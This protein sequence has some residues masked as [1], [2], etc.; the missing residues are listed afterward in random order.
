MKSFWV[1]CP[2][3]KAPCP[4]ASSCMSFGS[5]SRQCQQALSPTY[6]TDSEESRNSHDSIHIQT[7]LM[8]LLL[9]NAKNSQEGVFFLLWRLQNPHQQA[10]VAPFTQLLKTPLC[11]KPLTLIWHQAGSWQ[12]TASSSFHPPP[13]LPFAFCPLVASCLIPVQAL[14]RE[15]KVVFATCPCC[16]QS[17]EPRTLM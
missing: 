11:H 14:D 7:S 3:E 17:N 15:G 5:G 6:N 13:T 1:D 12:G 8:K 9:L 2:G 16:T 4:P 10:R